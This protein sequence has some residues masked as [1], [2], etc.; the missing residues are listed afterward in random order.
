MHSQQLKEKQEA[1]SFSGR[2]ML[3]KLCGTWPADTACSQSS[4]L[5]RRSESMCVQQPAV[6]RFLEAVPSVGV[7][8]QRC[9]A[10]LPAHA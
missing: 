9:D 6:P 3:D 2:L 10:K 4:A 1:V 8:G 5:L 7:E